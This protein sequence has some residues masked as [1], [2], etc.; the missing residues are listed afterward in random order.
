MRWRARRA[1]GGFQAGG[2]RAGGRGRVV[3]RHSG[4]GRQRPQANGRCG[5][6][7]APLPAG[8]ASAGGGGGGGGG[9]RGGPGGESEEARGLP[10]D[11]PA[12]LAAGG[13]LRHPRAEPAHAGRGPRPGVCTRGQVRPKRKKVLAGSFGFARGLE[14]SG[15]LK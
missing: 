13:K 5:R 15:A 2:P 14:F 7:R 1:V 4:D 6:R 10:R 12:D 9:G 11:P 3:D 8:T